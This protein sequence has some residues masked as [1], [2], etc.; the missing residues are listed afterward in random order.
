[1]GGG[2]TAMSGGECTMPSC[3][4]PVADG[5]ATGGLCEQHLNSHEST[6]DEPEPEPETAGPWDDAGFQNPETA[7]WAADRL[8]REQWMGHVGKKPFAPWGDA[9][10]P[11]DCSKDGHT[12]ADECGCDARYKWG[13]T[14]HYVDG[15]TLSMYEDD[16]R[17]RTDGRAFLQWPD[18]PHTYVD[19][20]DVRDA[21]S[22]EVHPGFIAVIN[23]L[24]ISYADISFSDG[25]VHVAYKGELPEDVKQAAWQLDSEPWGDNDDLPSIEIYDGKRVCVDTGKHVPGTPTETREWDSDA[26]LDILDENDQLPERPPK[27]PEERFDASEYE[28]DATASGETANDIRDLYAALDRLDTH[29]VADKTIVHRWNDNASTSDG[30]RAFAP[31]WGKNSN[32]TANV[33]NDKVWYDSG[34][35]GGYGGPVVMALIDAGE[36]NHRNASP[37]KATGA[38]WWTGVEHLRDLG[39]EIPELDESGRDGGREIIATLPNSPRTRAA[40]KGSQW[41]DNRHGE[42]SSSAPSQQELY[43]RVR[44]A[45]NDGMERWDQFVLDA[46]MGGGK[47]YNFFGALADRGEQGAYFAP[48]IELYEQA[49]DYAEANDIPRDDCYILPSIKRHC[50]TWGGEHGEEQEHLVKRLYRLGV[51]PKTIHNLLADELGCKRNDSGKCEYEHKCDFEPD[52]YQVLIGHYAHAHLP[53]VTK[54]RHCAFDEDPQNAFTT[55]LGGSELIKG[56]NAFLGLHDS[57]PFNG[58]DDLIQHRNDD[59]RREEGLAWFDRPE[60]DF[61]PDERNAVRFED[62]GFH[63]YAPLAVYTI[64]SAEPI[65]DGYSFERTPLPGLGN[66]AQFFTTSEQHGEHYVEL[67]TPPDLQYANA[68]IA[69]DGTPL[70]QDGVPVEWKNALDRPMGYRQ[71]LTDGERTEFLRETQGNVYLQTSEFIKPYSSGRWNHIEEDAALLAAVRESYGD[72]DPPVV[73]TDKKVRDEYEDAGFEREGLAETFDHPG[74]LRG[75]DEYGDCRLAVQL[76]SSHHGDHEVRRRAAM[77][78]ETVAPEGKGVERTMGSELGDKLVYQMREAQS[79]QNALRVG[80]D[81]NGSLFVFD[82]CAFPDWI[83][84]EEGVADVSM[85]NETEQTV[86]DVWGEFTESEHS[87]G[88][89]SASVIE[90]FDGST[91]S[92]YIRRCLNRLADRGYLEKNPD[93]EDGRKSVWTDSGL[94]ELGDHQTAEI[95]LPDVAFG[96]GGSQPGTKETGITSL[97]A[98]LSYFSL[99]HPTTSNPSLEETSANSGEAAP[100]SNRGAGGPGG[101]T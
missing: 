25:G 63:A 30:T 77:L 95:E 23:R 17:F 99:R 71:V 34:D 80:R 96:G 27:P 46:I 88:V 47:T 36:M 53:H 33:V 60:F 101:P 83:P 70:V 52:E 22:G 87:R 37:R 100:L 64:L 54:Q 74:N 21:E 73:F 15:E 41:H 39:F 69:L 5:R 42:Q 75:S 62:E 91:T 29:H 90:A 72:G 9:D 79:A 31:T 48:R 97:Y 16:P 10:A 84:V 65:E 78:G 81:G 57:P 93:P 68:I 4:N 58:W 86:C 98:K 61:E 32:G 44:G 43:D 85:W 18:D 24:G 76:G 26:L 13:Y 49:V 38:D 12:T 3:E 1:M 28:A 66:S 40:T 7:V 59:E 2:G 94:A 19:G 55:Y 14:E 82:T 35:E 67:S 51:Q 20:D 56:V 11:A 8:K 92:Q 45:I 50:G 6:P 89:D